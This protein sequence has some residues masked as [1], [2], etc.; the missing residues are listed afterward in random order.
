MLNLT[1]NLACAKF[2]LHFPHLKSIE[3]CIHPDWSE[4]SSS[5]TWL[6]EDCWGRVMYLLSNECTYKKK[7]GA[8]V[9]KMFA[10]CVNLH[11]AKDCA[12]CVRVAGIGTVH[13]VGVDGGRCLVHCVDKGSLFLRKTIK[14]FRN[15]L[16][17]LSQTLTLTRSRYAYVHLPSTA[18]MPS[19]VNYSKK[20]LLLRGGFASSLKVRCYCCNEKGVKFFL[21]SA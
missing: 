7:V 4:M 9:C 5:S 19:F 14:A 16:A 15:L 21:Q 1:C 17:P 12:Q 20:I 8:R 18:S 6:P 2:F 13:R 3:I 11:I 10:R